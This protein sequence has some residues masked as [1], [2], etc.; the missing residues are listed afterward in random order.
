VRNLCCRRSTTGRCHWA[1]ARQNI[2]LVEGVP[3]YNYASAAI[4]RWPPQRARACSFAVVVAVAVVGL[5]SGAESRLRAIHQSHRR[6][7]SDGFIIIIRAVDARHFRGGSR[8]SHL[9]S[10]IAVVGP[11][12]LG[13]LVTACR[14]REDAGLCD[15]KDICIKH[16]AESFHS[17]RR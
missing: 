4:V 5:R 8:I 1:I 12:G 6:M 3:A 16:D 15:T 13:G 10:P 17:S 7:L 14:C 2:P 11:V 9:P